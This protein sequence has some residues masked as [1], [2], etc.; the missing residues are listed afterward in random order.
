MTT[1]STNESISNAIQDEAQARQVLKKMYYAYY[2]PKEAQE[3]MEQDY[4]YKLT[5]ARINQLYHGFRLASLPR[6]NR[7]RLFVFYADEVTN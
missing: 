5:T 7:K 4:N 2:T 1:V 3:E 6:F